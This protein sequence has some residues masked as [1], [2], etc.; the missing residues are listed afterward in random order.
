MVKSL[1]DKVPAVLGNLVDR[2]FSSLKVVNS[3]L[4]VRYEIGTLIPPIPCIHDGACG[5][6][7]MKL[8]FVVSSIRNLLPVR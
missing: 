1:G 5:Y 7:I 8:Q 3:L 6:S 2:L 4:Q